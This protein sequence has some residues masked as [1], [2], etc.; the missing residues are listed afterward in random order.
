MTVTHTNKTN[1][2]VVIFRW[3]ETLTKVHYTTGGVEF[4]EVEDLI[5]RMILTG[6]DEG[7]DYKGWN[8][9]ISM[10]SEYEKIIKL[11]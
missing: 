11:D 3:D 7:N 10:K 2:N 4:D 1:G 6:A 5:D 9:K 8:C